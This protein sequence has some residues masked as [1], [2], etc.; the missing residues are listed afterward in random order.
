MSQIV[1]VFCSGKNSPSIVSKII[2]TITFRTTGNCRFTNF[3]FV[4]ANGKPYEPPG[5]NHRRPPN[6]GGDEISYDYDA[7]PIPADGYN[8]VYV[9][10]SP[11]DG[12]GSGTIKNK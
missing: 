8:F 9:T 12:D 7:A 4:D 1:K 2:D 6:G 3:Y 10:D 11:A 5:I